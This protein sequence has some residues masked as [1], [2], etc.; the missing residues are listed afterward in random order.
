[1]TP[2]EFEKVMGELERVIGYPCPAF[3]KKTIWAKS[4]DQ[5]LQYLKD[6]LTIYKFCWSE[7]DDIEEGIKRHNNS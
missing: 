3:I 6:R 2:E 1:M 4:K 7:P 5:P